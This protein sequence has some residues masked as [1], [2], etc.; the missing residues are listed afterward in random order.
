MRSEDPPTLLVQLI[1][2][3]EYQSVKIAAKIQKKFYY[4][5]PDK[6]YH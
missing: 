4:T 1:L 6:E 5:V 3:T 2:H